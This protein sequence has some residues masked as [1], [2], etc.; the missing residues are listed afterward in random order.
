[1]LFYLNEKMF[2]KLIESYMNEK[3]VKYSQYNIELPIISFSSENVYKKIEEIHN[4]LP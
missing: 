3:K 4:I 2:V 1:M